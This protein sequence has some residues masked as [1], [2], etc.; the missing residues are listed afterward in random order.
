MPTFVDEEPQ[1][2]VD[3]DIKNFELIEKAKVSQSTFYK[4]KNSYL[5]AIGFI[6]VYLLI[7]WGG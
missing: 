4:M 6:K 1:K 7:D 2:M 5:I 3:L